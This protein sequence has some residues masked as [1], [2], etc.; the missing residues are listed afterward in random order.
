MVVNP[1]DENGLWRQFHQI[2]QSLSFLS[3]SHDL[4][5]LF[6]LNILNS[7]LSD[8]SPNNT[9]DQ[10]RNLLDEVGWTDTNKFESKT[11]L[12]C[13]KTEFQVFIDLIGV[14]V[15]AGVDSSLIDT[16]WV[17]DHDEFAKNDTIIQYVEEI[18]AVSL[19]RKSIFHIIIIL[20]G[21]VN[22]IRESGNFFS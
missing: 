17:N 3:K 8:D 7:N 5:A 2:L 1:T 20:Q 13:R 10:M 14:Q 9:E 12:A 4:R 16:F 11:T 19:Y 6:E 21:L 18:V 15:L 22:H